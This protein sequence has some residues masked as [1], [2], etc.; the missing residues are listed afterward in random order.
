MKVPPSHYK[1]NPYVW[2]LARASFSSHFSA[3]R[4][5]SWPRSTLV[6][7]RQP[8]LR[9][10]RRLVSLCISTFSIAQQRASRPRGRPRRLGCRFARKPLAE[11]KVGEPSTA[12]ARDEQRLVLVLSGSSVSSL[13]CADTLRVRTDSHR[14]T[15]CCRLC[16]T[17]HA[18]QRPSTFSSASPCSAVRHPTSRQHPP[19]AT[20]RCSRS[21]VGRAGSDGTVARLAQVRVRRH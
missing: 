13:P 7:A 2:L 6:R 20:S 11:R 5:R 17:V 21:P 4:C 9:S 14:I 15:S 16:F 1:I 19:R 3:A 10:R 18:R 12:A 8:L